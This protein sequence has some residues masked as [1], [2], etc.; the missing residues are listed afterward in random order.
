MRQPP[1]PVVMRL[2][3]YGGEPVTLRSPLDPA[4]PRPE[5]AA[6]GL[7]RRRPEAADLA[8]DAPMYRDYRRVAMLDPV[9]LADGRY[10]DGRP[11]PPVIVDGL[12]AVDHHGRPAGE[13]VLRLTRFHDPRCG[14]CALMHS[15]QSDA[16]EAAG[17]ASTAVEREPG[18]RYA[19]AHRVRLDVGTGVRVAAHQIGGTCDGD[20]HELAIT[21]VT[22]QPPA[23]PPARRTVHSRAGRPRPA[24]SR[25]PA[26][27]TTPRG[28][29]ARHGRAT[30]LPGPQAPRIASCDHAPPS[31][32]VGCSARRSPGCARS[33]SPRWWP[34][35]SSR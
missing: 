23:G 15:P 33:S 28:R 26:S 11:G 21:A 24:S 32:G 34:R 4:T 25:R 10:L 17:G 19:R 7:V 2:G 5:L 14:C 8:Y 20:G 31:G 13:A 16:I 22:G 29:R 6:D 9:E 30:S 35:S 12:R 1:G 18:F 3:A 27:L